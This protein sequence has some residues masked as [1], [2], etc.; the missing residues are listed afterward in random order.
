MSMA[1]STVRLLEKAHPEQLHL[2]ILMMLIDVI[3]LYTV[4]ARIPAALCVR[5]LPLCV[6][7]STFP[8]SCSFISSHDSPSYSS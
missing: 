4:Q 2:S 1:F 7:S 8:I 6:P 3:S 5:F